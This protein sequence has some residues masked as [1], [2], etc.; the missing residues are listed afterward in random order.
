M[1]QRQHNMATKWLGNNILELDLSYWIIRDN[2]EGSIDLT[3]KIKFDFWCK[4][5]DDNK[6]QIC[7]SLMGLAL[8][9]KCNL[10]I[11]NLSAKHQLSPMELCDMIARVMHQ[12]RVDVN[13]IETDDER[14]AKVLD[15][16]N[17]NM[18]LFNKISEKV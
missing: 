5:L 1:D 4:R 13:S 12:Q 11:N 16:E 7:V 10:L 3:G 6:P 9:N 8:K 14:I 17:R 18:R 2:E 15:K